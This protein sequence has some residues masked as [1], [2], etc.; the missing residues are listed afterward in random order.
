MKSQIRILGIDDSPFMFNEKYTSV[1]GV[2]MR[3]GEYLEG[4]IKK[5]IS[6]DGNDSTYIC[7]KMINN[8]RHRNQL[9]AVMIDG[10]AFGGFN[11]VDIEQVKIKKIES[12][13][14]QKRV[15]KHVKENYQG[16]TD[17]LEFA[18]NVVES[19]INDAGGV[20]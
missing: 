4:V 12:M 18:T 9:R 14:P 6:I 2:V 11:V 10:I 3:G 13:S 20:L 7:K 17:I 16:N 15:E 1:I 5:E 19:A 8:S